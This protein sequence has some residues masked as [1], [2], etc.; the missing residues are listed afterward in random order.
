MAAPASAYKDRQFLAVIGD[1]D[2]V[3]GLLLAGVGHVT[4]PP[5]N[6]KNF[7][8]VDNKTETSAIEAAFDKFTEERKD[9]AIL[10][11]N[12]HIAER[13][14]HRV[15]AYTAAFPSLL[16]IPSKDHPYDPEKD[17]VLKRVRR[18]FGE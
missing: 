16:E 4:P 17:S 11:I 9:I 8:V 3:T 18:L 1:E 13:I 14:R 10:L 6:Q 15:D 2:S 7:L 12:Q 5:D